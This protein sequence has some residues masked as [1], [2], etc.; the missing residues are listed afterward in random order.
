ME[1]IRKFM[2]EYKDEF[3]QDLEEFNLD[4][5]R[6]TRRK[7]ESYSEPDELPVIAVL[8]EAERHVE[9]LKTSSNPNE[10]YNAIQSLHSL[11]NGPYIKHI[12][13]FL[14]EC[15]FME[16]LFPIINSFGFP[17]NSLVSALNC[18]NTIIANVSPDKIHCFAW[19][20]YFQF[21]LNNLISSNYYNAQYFL[22]YALGHL[23]IYDDEIQ[24]YML[25]HFCI[26]KLQKIVDS[27]VSFLT[28]KT[29][30]YLCDL[31]SDDVDPY[32]QY[33]FSSDESDVPQNPEEEESQTFAKTFD[34]LN[35]FGEL[36]F[37]KIIVEKLFNTMNEE[38]QTFY[39]NVFLIA[40][41]LPHIPGSRPLG[42]RSLVTM[43]QINPKLVIEKL[44]QNQK[45]LSL[46]Y[47]SKNDENPL[48]ISTS[49][50][51]I[52][53]LLSFNIECLDLHKIVEFLHK[54]MTTFDWEEK[55]K[56]SIFTL[57]IISVLSTIPEIQNDLLPENFLME[58]DARIM[59]IPYNIKEALI[60]M[61]CEVVLNATN[62]TKERIFFRYNFVDSICKITSHI[63]ED[64]ENV[65]VIVFAIAE[66]TQLYVSKSWDFISLDDF[67]ELVDKDFIENIQEREDEV[68]E[69]AKYIFSILDQSD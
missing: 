39:L 17:C 13:Q 9:M 15:Q 69:A 19:K 5:I 45:A 12:I 26:E 4:K 66:F 11:L 24:R 55:T 67:R 56:S 58:I 46:L 43:A 16:I 3:R 23:V 33:C 44:H 57:K 59:E 40:V 14:I 49:L 10:I 37:F 48:I 7:E 50:E 32:D 68:G 42:L 30:I 64:N 61:L 36:C 65:D 60:V 47:S 1:K 52:H 35:W 63:E 62:Q 51:L 31:D 34:S 28:K 41:T 53:A 22:W 27:S 21:L 20:E 8:E 38:A 25:D 2:E 6:E 54:M 29:P 18:L